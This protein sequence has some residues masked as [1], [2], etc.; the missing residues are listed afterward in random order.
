MLED[1]RR[2]RRGRL[3]LAWPM[4]WLQVLFLRRDAHIDGSA[5]SVSAYFMREI[6]RFREIMALKSIVGI[7][8]YA[9]PSLHGM[10]GAFH[11]LAVSIIHT[12]SSSSSFAH[13][14]GAG[15]SRLS[16]LRCAIKCGTAML[17][18]A[19]AAA[20]LRHDDGH[21]SRRAASAAFALMA[22][23]RKS[24]SPR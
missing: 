2:S 9:S 10:S 11:R 6:C 7:A 1:T 3:K 13:H 14:A 19:A 12:A 21:R 17:L 8:I 23:P 4:L 22:M 20:S 16:C 24:S 15:A 18:R 5:A